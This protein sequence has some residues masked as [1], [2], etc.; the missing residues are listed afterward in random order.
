MQMCN[1]KEAK[2]KKNMFMYIDFAWNHIKGKQ[3]GNEQFFIPCAIFRTKL[4]F[5]FLRNIKYNILA[6][7]SQKLKWAF[8]IAGQLQSDLA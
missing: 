6:H 1:E 3:D 2:W 7:K 5:S 8:L 4:F